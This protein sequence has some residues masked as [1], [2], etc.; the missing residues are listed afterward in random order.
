MRAISKTTARKIEELEKRIAVLT[1]ALEIASNCKK[2]HHPQDYIKMVE[3]EWKN[4]E[5][6]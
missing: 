5:G 1:R 6:M 2:R 4:R 3:V